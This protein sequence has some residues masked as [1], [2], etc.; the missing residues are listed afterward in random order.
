MKI[1]TRMV[2]I[3]WMYIQVHQYAKP[4]RKRAQPPRQRRQNLIG[5][6]PSDDYWSTTCKWSTIIVKQLRINLRGSIV[7]PRV[8]MSRR[9][10]NGIKTGL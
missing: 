3:Q 2:N 6:K 10:V 1:Y 4:F 8:V 5:A 7:F 9:G